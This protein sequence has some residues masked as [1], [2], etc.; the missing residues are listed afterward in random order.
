MT[1]WRRWRRQQQQQQHHQRVRAANERTRKRVKTRF[2]DQ[3]SIEVSMALPSAHV[4]SAIV[5]TTTTTATNETYPHLY[6]SFIHSYKT[7]I[8]E[9]STIW[10]IH[11]FFLSLCFCRPSVRHWCVCGMLFEQ[12]CLVPEIFSFS[13]TTTSTFV[14]FI[15]IWIYCTWHFRHRCR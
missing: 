15:L 1:S 4:F 5:C 10:F 12:I 13:S 8:C 2:R 9:W 6:R 14:V 3:Q 11:I 7:F